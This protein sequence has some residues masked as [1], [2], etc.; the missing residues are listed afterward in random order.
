VSANHAQ[1]HTNY[2]PKQRVHKSFLVECY[3]LYDSW[4]NDPDSL[5]HIYSIVILDS[6]ESNEVYI[7]EI[8]DPGLLAAC[9]SASKQ[10]KDYLS[11]DTAT[12]G[13]FEADFWQAMHVE[14]NTLMNDF[15]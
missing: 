4:I 5:F 14:L 9:S 12:K 15:K 13:P 6:W 1:V 3:L 11:W 10:N 2:H 7:M 8:T